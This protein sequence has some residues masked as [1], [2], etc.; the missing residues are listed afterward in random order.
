MTYS[1]PAIQVASIIIGF[2]VGMPMAGAVV[3]A[4]LVGF[5]LFRG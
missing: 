4:L 1:L 3:S 2:A 5:V